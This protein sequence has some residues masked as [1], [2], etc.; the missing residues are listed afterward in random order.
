LNQTNDQLTQ[1]DPS[2]VLNN[3][4]ISKLNFG[5]GLFLLNQE[6]FFASI[7]VP[8]IL[9]SKFQRNGILAESYNPVIYVSGGVILGGKSNLPIR[10]A[11]L[12]KTSKGLPASFDLST[13]VLLSKIL[14]AGV[15]LRNLNTAAVIGQLDI[16]EHM[17]VG[18]SM[19]FP[20]TKHASSTTAFSTYE[21]S[22]NVNFAAFKKQTVIPRFF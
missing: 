6:K 9:V 21:F 15:S 1:G 18:Y 10:P 3:T 7:S 14:W 22:V 11:F 16:T 2:Y 13:S 19:D 17:R 4:S 5:G 12:L 20:F 8:K